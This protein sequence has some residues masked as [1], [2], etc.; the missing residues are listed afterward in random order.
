[1]GSQPADVSDLAEGLEGVDLSEKSLAETVATVEVASEKGT[2]EKGEDEELEARPDL[3]LPAPVLP[4]SSAHLKSLNIQ[5]SLAPSVS[6]FDTPRS[7]MVEDG[8]ID[9]RSLLDASLDDSAVDHEYITSEGL[10]DMNT[11][12]G[13]LI[14]LPSEAGG[15]SPR[16]KSPVKGLG[17]SSPRTPLRASAMADDSNPL[18][19]QIPSTSS[20]V[21]DMTTP[22]TVTSKLPDVVTPPAGGRRR[23]T[24]SDDRPMPTPDFNGTTTHPFE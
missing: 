10:S 12:P 11:P 6:G 21:I 18:G 14:E 4:L 7:M 19:L 1:M 17:K 16:L 5:S 2:S 9:G 8:S 3:R 13:L 24:N 15:A 22:V 20:E 23:E